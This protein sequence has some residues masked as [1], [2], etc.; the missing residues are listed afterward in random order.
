MTKSTTKPDT[1]GIAEL[2]AKLAESHDLTKAKAKAVIDSLRDDVVAVL[3]S[4]NRV[5]LF[6]LG[7]FEV[8]DTKP[9]MGRNPK[10]G[11]KISIPAGRKVVF[12][13]AKGLKDQM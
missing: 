9:K 5:N 6:G 11:E 12:K 7:T 10:T 4:G 1:F 13:V 3:L 8:R 2:A